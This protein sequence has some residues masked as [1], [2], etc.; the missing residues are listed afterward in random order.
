MHV[1][2]RHMACLPVTLERAVLIQRVTSMHNHP[3]TA[4]PLCFLANPPVLLP[5]AHLKG[6]LALRACNDLRKS[7]LI[8]RTV[9]HCLNIWNRLKICLT[10][11]TGVLVLRKPRVEALCAKQVLAFFASDRVKHDFREDCAQEVL[12]G[13]CV[14][15]QLTFNFVES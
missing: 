3:T 2:S 10:H 5:F 7:F 1:Q 8:P 13:V 14:G 15:I 4:L 11:R 9:N 12:V 6:L